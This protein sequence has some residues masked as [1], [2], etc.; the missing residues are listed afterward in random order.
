MQLTEFVK[1]NMLRHKCF[2]IASLVIP[3]N[4]FSF[5]SL[6]ASFYL[7]EAPNV[8]LYRILVEVRKRISL[9]AS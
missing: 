1:C 7:G 9:L 8:I 3:T 6:I 4:Y 2:L 5:N